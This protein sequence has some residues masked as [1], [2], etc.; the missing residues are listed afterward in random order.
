MILSRRGVEMLMESGCQC[1][2]DDSPDDMWLGMCFRNMAIPAVHN[3]SFHQAST[4]TGIQ[5][6]NRY[7]VLQPVFSS[8]T[9]IQFLHLS[10]HFNSTYLE[11]SWPHSV[12]FEI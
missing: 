3:P 5:F 8:A 2:S 4:A 9:G 12:V 10:N 6:C 11:W 1:S 7:S